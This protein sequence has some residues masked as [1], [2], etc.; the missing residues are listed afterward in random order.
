[1]TREEGFDLIREYDTKRPA[2]LDWY[3]EITGISEEEFMK[4]IR[5][6]RENVMGDSV[7]KA[8]E[9]CNVF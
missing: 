5:D 1:M 6:H 4:V 8:C 9:N 3:L 7:C 2:I